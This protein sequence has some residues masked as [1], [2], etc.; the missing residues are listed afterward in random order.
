MNNT[1]GGIYQVRRSAS[2][3][4][5]LQMKW[6]IINHPLLKGQVDFTT[7]E[8]EQGND[9]VIVRIPCLNEMWALELRYHKSINELIEKLMINHVDMIIL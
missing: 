9:E 4:H 8:K 6:H 7:L 1:F 5:L 3:S 2:A